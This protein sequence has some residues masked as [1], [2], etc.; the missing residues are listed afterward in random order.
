MTDAAL[1]AT[2]LEKTFGEGDI[3]VRAIRGI[4]LKVARGEVVL[5][6][7]PSGSGKTTLLSMLGAMMRPTKGSVLVDGT[8]LATLP[9][10]NSPDSGRAASGS[11]SKT[12]TCYPRSPPKKMSSTRSTSREPLGAPL[13]NVQGPC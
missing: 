13:T 7:G 9:R 3:Q 10:R 1:L 5:I 4:D 8:D 2:G 6:M 11:C 12:S